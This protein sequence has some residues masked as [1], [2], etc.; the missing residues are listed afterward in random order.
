MNFPRW[1]RTATTALALV[2]T[3]AAG[4]I[5]FPAK[6]PTPATWQARLPPAESVTP[7]DWRSWW[8]SG[9][10]LLY[11]SCGRMLVLDAG[12]RECTPAPALFVDK[13]TGHA[14]LVLLD[15]PPYDKVLM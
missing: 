12:A 1:H 3:F 10:Y 14:R 2:S 7:D 9:E 11:E 8:L 13:S 5:L 6:A 15:C 4:V